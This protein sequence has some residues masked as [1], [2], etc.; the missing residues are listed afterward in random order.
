MGECE[1]LLVA[2]ESSLPRGAK[3]KP[4][5]SIPCA[6][7]F[8]IERSR[9]AWSLIVV[10]FAGSQ[11]TVTRFSVMPRSFSVE[12][13][14]LPPSSEYLPASSATP[15][16]VL[17]AALVKTSAAS[18]QAQTDATLITP[19]VG[20]SADRPEH[21]VGQLARAEAHR[22]VGREARLGFC[23]DDRCV[24][25]ILGHR[26]GVERYRHDLRRAERERQPLVQFDEFRQR[27]NWRPRR[28]A[29]DARPADLVAE[30]ERVRRAAVNEPERHPRVDRMEDR[31]LPFDPEQIAA[32]RTVD[33]EPLRRAGEEIGNHRVDGYPP[34]CD[35]D[36][37]LT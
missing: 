5:M 8:G 7:A 25:V 10:G 6:T 9:N 24:R 34:A 26:G 23:F 15:Y 2:V 32:L 31:A 20:S 4:T 14:E 37:R 19:N 27:R 3:P 33:D 28:I 11:V 35:R 30:D 12:K 13:K 29:F 16:T 22:I 18:R 21:C 36:A 1:A 17:D